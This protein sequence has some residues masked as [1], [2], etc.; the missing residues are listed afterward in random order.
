MRGVFQC[1]LCHWSSLIYFLF[2]RNH[3][4][5][6]A[7]RVEF[8]G[9]EI[10]INEV[11]RYMR[12]IFFKQMYAFWLKLPYV[13]F[14]I[15]FVDLL[16]VCAYNVTAGKGRGHCLLI[17]DSVGLAVW[18]SLKQVLLYLAV[19][20]LYQV[21]PYRRN[22]TAYHLSRI[23]HTSRRDKQGDDSRLKPTSYA[24]LFQQLGWLIGGFW[25][26]IYFLF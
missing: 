22:G 23:P 6:R 26:F 4:G 9:M 14:F 25:F 21:D 12:H 20:R 17:G 19:N 7:P 5:I 13:V 11:M 16:S 2:C 3:K 15:F 18:S 1:V 24:L 10:R 8:S